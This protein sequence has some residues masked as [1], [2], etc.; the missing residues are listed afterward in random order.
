MVTIVLPLHE[1]TIENRKAF[2]FVLSRID[3]SGIDVLI[4]LCDENKDLIDDRFKYL[5]VEE[6]MNIMKEILKSVETE[7][8]WF[9]NVNVWLP[10]DKIISEIGDS[11]VYKPFNDIILLNSEIQNDSFI[12][13][14]KM[15]IKEDNIEVKTNESIILKKDFLESSGDF[16]INYHVTNAKIMKYTGLCFYGSTNFNISKVLYEANDFYLNKYEVEDFDMAIIICLY[17][18]DKSRFD[19]VKRAMSK[20]NNQ[21]IKARVYCWQLF[22]TAG[23]LKY[24]LDEFFKQ[25][26]IE[27]VYEKIIAND[28]NLDLFQKESLLNLAASKAILDGSKKLVFMDADTWSKD[29]NWWKKICYELDKG[30]DY[31]CQGFRYFSDTKEAYRSLYSVGSSIDVELSKGTYRQP[32]LCWALNSSFFKK[33]NGF[34]KFCLSGSGDVLFM[35]EHLPDAPYDFSF[36]SKMNW[37]MDIIRSEQPRG[38]LSYANSNVIHENHGTFNSRSYVTSRS[39][40]DYVESPVLEI[41]SIDSRGLLMWRNPKCQLRKLL[42]DKSL[43]QTEETL[44]KRCKEIGLVRQNKYKNVYGW[45]DFQDIYRKF[46]REA[47]EDSLIMEIGSFVGKS[48]IHLA[49]E[50]QNSGKNIKLFSVDI[51]PKLSS[52]KN[53]D[54]TKIYYDS[55]VDKFDGYLYPLFIENIME[56][57]VY[58]HI[59]PVHMNIF[60]FI[61]PF[62]DE[63]FFA[64]FLD[65]DHEYDTTKKAMHKLWKKVKIGGY[66]GGHDYLC[67]KWGGVKKAIDEFAVENNISLKIIGTSFLMKRI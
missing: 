38:I 23:I 42:S 66:L 60:D 27:V 28:N 45:F 20:W 3:D 10:F 13:G 30:D 46:V 58:N 43:I 53:E 17:G 2:D 50:I 15:I 39:I 44:T 36:F 21:N 41:V 32:G 29:I 12:D 22:S 11:N 67:P 55:G 63:S 5:F 37:W 14:K 51:F 33:M 34:N 47:P 19:A 40:I 61:K 26:K 7:Y 62:S 8:V 25:L 52:N 56:S 48:T 59:I 65:A 16:S 4:T 6:D 57:G 49:T 31:I 64:I 18:D 1:Y 54:I 35:H 24:D 9:H